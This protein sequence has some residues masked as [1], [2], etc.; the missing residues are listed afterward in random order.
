MRQYLLTISTLFFLAISLMGQTRSNDGIPKLSKGSPCQIMVNNQP[1]IMLAAEVN[2]SS[3][4]NLVYMEKVWD[5][6]VKMNCN[7]ALVP[8]SWELL[9][10]EE[11]KFD[12]TLVEGLINGARQ[13]H[14]RI[15]FLWFGTWK[16]TW[17]T[18]APEW[19]K[20]DIRRFPRAQQKPGINWGVIS[21]FSQEASEA[22]AKAFARLMRK[23]KELDEAEKTV[24]MVQ[25]ENEVGVHAERDY[26]KLA[27]EKFNASVPA[28][29][30]TYLNQNKDQLKPELK[31]AWSLSD[32]SQKGTWS[33]VF[34][35]G[36]SEIFMAWYYASY[37]N[38]IV[39]AGKKE[40]P[41]PMYVN[42]WIV[43]DKT[44]KLG[45]YP[46]G[47]PVA[48]MINIWRAGAPSID[49]YAPDIYLN[50]YKEVCAEYNS[51]GNPL[52]IPENNNDKRSAANAVY[53]FSKHSAIGYG[54]FGIDQVADD[55][56]LN[57][58]YKILGDLMPY[59]N[60]YRG[61]DNITGFLLNNGEAEESEFRGYKIKVQSIPNKDADAIP[62]NAMII[63]TSENEFLM[64]GTNIRIEFSPLEREK[65]ILDA[66]SLE[67]GE[68]V[69]NKWV[70]GRRLNGDERTIRFGKNYQILK[71]RLYKY[72]FYQK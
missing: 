37:I 17:S 14:L 9:E 60:K 63:A 15:V 62:A 30:I 22:D 21:P 5:K 55:M 53:A 45:G 34:R 59:L 4:S 35:E 56:P 33:E 40:Y 25:V 16:N 69:D 58:A 47:G 11:G 24:V 39:E 18:Y 1:F 27:D 41:L 20:K 3:S 67:E 28:K 31:K 36:S 48:K 44:S 26:S 46:Q 52:F 23:V 10:P 70:A 68:F 65:F 8:V 19:V 7:T 71:L 57:Q 6:L 50:S 66:L 61:T 43:Q 72:P 54:P 51:L 12:F 29:L 2:N 64:T 42:A 38:R 49:L 32:Y 13:H